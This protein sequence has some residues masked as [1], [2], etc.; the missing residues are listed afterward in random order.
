MPLIF[1]FL[2]SEL[3][4]NAA[5]FPPPA[6]LNLRRSIPVCYLQLEERDFDL[7][8]GAQSVDYSDRHSSLIVCLNQRSHV[9]SWLFLAV[10]RRQDLSPEIRAIMAEPYFMIANIEYLLIPLLGWFSWMQGAVVVIRE[11]KEQ[12]TTIVL[13]FCVGFLHLINVSCSSIRVG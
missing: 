2:V 6:N 3:R 12:G 10:Q 8:L 1:G 4:Y 11:W 9:E 13:P 5:F 7:G